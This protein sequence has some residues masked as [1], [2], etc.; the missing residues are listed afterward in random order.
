[1]ARVGWVPEKGLRTVPKCNDFF[2]D[3]VP[4]CL[5]TLHTTPQDSPVSPQEMARG[6]RA[7]AVG[8]AMD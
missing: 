7:R 2:P 4:L 1:M 3:R 6:G 8:G 5:E